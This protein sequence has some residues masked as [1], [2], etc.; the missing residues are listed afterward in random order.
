MMQAAVTMIILGIVGM[1]LLK[2]PYRRPR[3]GLLSSFGWL[4]IAAA[5]YWDGDN[6]VI[7]VDALMYSGLWLSASIFGL[8]QS[9]W[10]R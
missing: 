3:L 7:A 10:G 8:T 2:L 4:A 6:G 9:R 1:M 5:L